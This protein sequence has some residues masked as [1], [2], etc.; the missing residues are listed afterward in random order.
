MQGKGDD[1]GK[2]FG[3]FMV[4]STWGILG[5]TDPA[6]DRLGLEVRDDEDMGQTLSVYGVGNGFYIVWPFWGP[7]TLRDSVGLT[8]DQFL[9]PL[10]YLRRWE[11]YTGIYTLRVTNDYSLNLGE[12][13]SLKSSAVEPYTALRDAYLQYR[14]KQIRE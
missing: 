2:E 10:T 12:Y 8:G 13:E 11:I 3:R 1:A 5:V 7:S 4:N 6:K 9:N 14:A